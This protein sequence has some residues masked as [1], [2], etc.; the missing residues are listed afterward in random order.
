MISKSVKNAVDIRKDNKIAFNVIK[1]TDIVHY[2]IPDSYVELEYIRGRSSGK[3]YITTDCLGSSD[4]L[5]VV[6]S[7]SIKDNPYGPVSSTNTGGGGLF[8]FGF[9]TN[10]NNGWYAYWVGTANGVSTDTRNATMTSGRLI[11]PFTNADFKN[12]YSVNSSDIDGIHFTVNAYEDA[13][14]EVP[15][16]ILN[17]TFTLHRNYQVWKAD[18]CILNLIPVRRLGDG[19]CGMFDTIEQKFY[20]SNT[21]YQF[22]GGPVKLVDGEGYSSGGDGSELSKLSKTK[23]T[24]NA[25]SKKSFIATV[26]NRNAGE[27]KG[28]KLT[29][30]NVVYVVTDQMSPYGEISAMLFCRYF[31]QRDRDSTSVYVQNINPNWT[32]LKA[33]GVEDNTYETANQNLYFS[34]KDSIEIVP[35]GNKKGDPSNMRLNKSDIIRIIHIPYL[36]FNGTQTS[37]INIG[38]IETTTDTTMEVC[39]GGLDDMARTT[40]HVAYGGRTDKWRNLNMFIDSSDAETSVNYVSFNNGV[41][42]AVNYSCHLDKSNFNPIDCIRIAP[43]EFL[44]KYT[45]TVIPGGSNFRDLTLSTFYLGNGQAIENYNQDA[46]LYNWDDK[47]C[48]FRIERKNSLY[49]HYLPASIFAENN[50]QYVGFYEVVEQVFYMADISTVPATVNGVQININGDSIANAERVVNPNN[51]INPIVF[52]RAYLVRSDMD[53]TDIVK[54]HPE[55]SYI[56]LCGYTCTVSEDVSIRRLIITNGILNSK[57]WGVNVSLAL[58]NVKMVC[59]GIDAYSSSVRIE[60]ANNTV[61]NLSGGSI[62]SDGATVALV[63]STIMSEDNAEAAIL[64]YNGCGLFIDHTA[65]VATNTAIYSYTIDRRFLNTVEVIGG[66]VSSNDKQAIEV[67]NTNLIVQDALIRCLATTQNVSIPSTY[68]DTPNN[69]GYCIILNGDISGNSFNGDYDISTGNTYETPNLDSSVPKCVE[70]DNG[71]YVTHA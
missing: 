7:L 4:T 11:T 33:D 55:V 28:I 63:D 68:E 62:K 47:I 66:E 64:G 31:P 40:W 16:W 43:H 50:S 61:I 56:D 39:V 42:D 36:Q 10:S 23:V 9:N 29:D 52:G 2:Y 51:P 44:K 17:N 59:T 58:D 41:V 46:P 69:T 25:A 26:L 3:S 45:K 8:G 12:I 71:M 34:N 30:S 54:N 20:S 6:C 27:F 37:F 35:T 14:H 65:V 53:I 49:R 57:H 48:Y 70:Y 22:K 21:Q 15:S 13:N 1:G 38:P 24:T 18:K 60:T 32:I 5:R 67:I 19:I